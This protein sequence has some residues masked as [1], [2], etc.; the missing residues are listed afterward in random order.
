M[1]KSSEISEIINGNP[2]RLNERWF[3][4]HYPSVLKK[5]DMY[6]VDISDLPFKQRLWHYVNEKPIYHLCHTCNVVQTTFNKN[7]N[8]GYRTYCSAKC[9]ATNN[10]TKNKR[11]ETCLEI[12]GVDNVA[13]NEDVK[14]KT[15]KTNIEIY[16]TKSTFQNKE[17]QEK[18]KKN[19]QEKYGVDHYFQSELFDKNSSKII[20]QEKYG[21]SNIFKTEHFKGKSKITRNNKTLQKYKNLINENEYTINNY[22]NLVFKMSHHVCG[23]EFEIMLH[24]I[25]YRNF[26]NISLCSNCYPISENSSICEKELYEYVSN[27]VDISSDRSVL[28]G[29]ELDI[30]IPSMNL[31]IEFNGLYWHSEL[32]KEEKYHLNKS[33]DCQNKG[34]FLMHIWED[35]WKYKKDI[36]KSIIN[37]RLGACIGRVYARK[38]EIR[39]VSAN[40]AKEFL[41]ENHIQ[42]FAASTVKLGL[43]YNNILFS[44]MTFGYRSTNTKKEFELIRFCNALN[45]NVVGSASKLFKYFLN[46]YENNEIISYSD[47]RLFDGKLYET[48]GFEKVH[49]SKPNFFWCSNHNDKR[50]HRL[51]YTKKELVKEG[52][53]HNKSFMDTMHDSGYY[54]IYGCGLVKWIYHR[55]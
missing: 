10:S 55:K 4:N 40:E 22:D 26:N 50:E 13:K 31:A 38:C 11:K 29:K 32:Y 48:L 39:E 6:C 2:S 42:G 28:A 20:K 30:Y 25:K 1:N 7:W 53:D 15:E 3:T 49:L 45:T 35:E 19:I 43:Y 33:L 14:I 27:I 52:Y 36:V 24:N 9:S 16:G 21:D 34:I 18:W 8:D 37:N 12:Y 23:A 54:R 47:F 44:L 17:V 5:V 46:N 41:N 51:T